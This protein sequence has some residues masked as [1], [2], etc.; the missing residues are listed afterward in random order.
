MALRRYG[1]CKDHPESARMRKPATSWACHLSVAW[2]EAAHPAAGLRLLQ[3]A[4]Y[5]KPAVEPC[6]CD[7]SVAVADWHPQPEFWEPEGRLCQSH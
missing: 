5:W 7:H 4:G 1:T 2:V 6:A 3:P